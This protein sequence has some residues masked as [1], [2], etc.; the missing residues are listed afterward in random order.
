MTLGTAIVTFDISDMLGEDYDTRRG[1]R[2]W[3]DTNVVDDTV[4]DVAGN[5]IRLGSG[6]VPVAADGTGSLTVWVPDGSSNPDSWQTSVHVQYVDSGT[7]DR[8]TRVFGPFTIIE[9]INL[10]DLVEEQEVP[11][12]YLTTVTTLLDGFVD[13]AH[14]YRDEAEDFRDAA[15]AAAD[16]AHDISGIVVD[17]DVV[18]VLVEDDDSATTGALAA[19]YARSNIT[20]AF[21]GVGKTRV[22]DNFAR[23]DV[24]DLNGLLSRSGHTYATSIGV[25]GTNRLAIIN[26]RMVPTGVTETGTTNSLGILY[27]LDDEPLGS[28][29]GEVVFTGGGTAT[30]GSENP[31]IGAAVRTFGRGSIQLAIYPVERPSNP[32]IR[33]QLYAVTE[34]DITPYPTIDEGTLAMGDFDRLGTTTYRVEMHRTGTDQ[35]TLVLPDGS[36]PVIDDTNVDATTG[37]SYINTYWG[38]KAAWQLRRNFST[39][40]YA[41]FTSIGSAAMPAPEVTPTPTGVYLPGLVTDYFSTRMPLDWR[42]LPVGDIDVRFIGRPQSWR[43]ASAMGFGIHGAT[44]DLSWRFLVATNGKL[45]VYLSTDGTTEAAVYESTVAIPNQ[46]TVNGVRFTRPTSTGTLTFYVTR[47]ENTTWSA[48]GS[49]VATGAGLLHTSAA[50]IRWGLGAPSGFTS[51]YKGLIREAEVRSDTIGGLIRA[52]LDLRT[53]WRRATWC[54]QRGNEWVRN[55]TGSFWRVDR[56]GMARQVHE[57]DLS[58]MV[59]WSLDP[60]MASTTGSAP[61]TGT[62]TCARVWVPEDTPCSAIGVYILGT[63]TSIVDSQNYF[64]L[65]NLDG[66]RLGVTAALLGSQLT[67]GSKSFA[68]ATPVDPI[69]AGEYVVKM[70]IN[71]TTAPTFARGSTSAAVN[72]GGS[73]SNGWRYFT[74]DTGRTTTGIPT[75]PGV[76]A[77]REDVS[78]AFALYA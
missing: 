63:G 72:M 7:K 65:H 6:A 23:A 43:P 78:Y 12:E 32:G 56:T 39:D 26:G 8:K 52:Q 71:G 62:V 40:G 57:T 41:E 28:V 49:T 58:N 37:L 67:T 61:A 38:P 13:E 18:K 51:G 5:A 77:A 10:A 2:V 25:G 34:P 22:W 60:S 30:T 9:S 46:S 48:L 55:G 19:G 21:G 54:D 59:G 31:V 16:L 53:A 1:I 36:R 14:G 24:A 64:A 33:W 75:S 76:S 70:L 29:T 66:T 44:G 45:Q 50:D 42:V 17:D 68:L 11:P 15:E 27:A 35:V 47:D 4:I 69:R 3:F 20:R 74:E 73:S